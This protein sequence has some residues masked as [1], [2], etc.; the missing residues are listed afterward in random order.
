MDIRYGGQSGERTVPSK[1][2]RNFNTEE[3]RRA[4]EGHRSSSGSGSC[5]PPWPSHV[6]RVKV[7]CQTIRPAPGQRSDLLH[8]C[9]AAPFLGLALLR[10]LGACVPPGGKK[11]NRRFTPQP[12]REAVRADDRTASFWLRPSSCA[13]SNCLLCRTATGEGCNSLLAG[14]ST[15]TSRSRSDW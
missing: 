8:G 1:G 12:R 14:P 6:L 13:V 9:L 5:G 7:L 3:G 2:R 10:Q 15:N 4:A 11:A